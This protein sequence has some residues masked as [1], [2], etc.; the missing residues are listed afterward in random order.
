LTITDA[1]GVRV[2]Q[3]RLWPYF[4][5]LPQ[6]LARLRLGLLPGTYRVHAEEFGGK[7]KEIEIVVP[8]VAPAEPFVIDLR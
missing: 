2:V 3:H 1:G 4:D 7:K 5:D 6:R 8:A